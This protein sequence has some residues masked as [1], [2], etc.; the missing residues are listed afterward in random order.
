MDPNKTQQTRIKTR[1]AGRIAISLGA[2]VLLLAS[3]F[4]AHAQTTITIYVAANFADPLALLIS[5]YG[6][7]VDPTANFTVVSGAT[8]DLKNQIISLGN[9]GVGQ[10]DLFLAADEAAPADLATNYSGLV[11]GSPF[12]YAQGSLLL[13]SSIYNELDV[14]GGL[15]YPITQNLVVANP[16]TAPYGHAAA[17]VLASS[18]WVITTIPSGYVYTASNIENTYLAVA[19]GSYSSGFIAQSASC[20]YSGGVYNFNPNGITYSYKQYLY[21]DPSHPYHPLIQNGIEINR[22]TRT[23]DQTALLNSFV[24][25]LSSAQGLADIQYFCY[26]TPAADIKK[27]VR[28]M[29]K[30][31]VPQRPAVFPR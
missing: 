11:V 21:N 1:V 18:P 22:T 2:A 24:S 15:P 9:T 27:S 8:R 30:G 3:S 14:S 19:A 6:T 13:W 28:M 29:P 4:V 5:D 7:Y 25:F 12:T 16:T 20:T 17:E 31:K 10:A 23:S 26:T